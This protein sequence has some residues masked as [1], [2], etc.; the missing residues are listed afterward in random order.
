M[1]Y[2]AIGIGFPINGTKMPH[3]IVVDT[4]VEE[5]KFVFVFVDILISTISKV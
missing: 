1:A 3:S 4:S 5:I 2:F